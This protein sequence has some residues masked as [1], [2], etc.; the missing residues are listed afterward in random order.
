MKHSNQPYTDWELL[1]ACK[2]RVLSNTYYAQLKYEYGIPHSTLKRYLEKICPPLKCINAQHVHQMLKKGEVLRSKKLETINMSVHRIKF[3]RPTYINSDEEAFVV[4]SAE[5]EGSHWLP[6][7]VNT[8]GVELQLVIRAVNAR[9]STKEITPKAPSKYTRLVIKRV[10][11]I[12]EGHDKQRNNF[13]RP[14]YLNSDEEALLVALTEIEGA[15]GLPI[16]VNTL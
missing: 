2:I 6:I 8:L 10:K 14:T 16:Y 4:A 9:Q 12:E 1:N 15:H 7:Y 3:G 5:I 11:T 13:G